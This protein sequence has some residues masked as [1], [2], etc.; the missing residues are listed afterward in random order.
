MTC[1]GK[2][3]LQKRKKQR[4][5]QSKDLGS[6]SIW[7][8]IGESLDILSQA[9]ENHPTHNDDQRRENRNPKQQIDY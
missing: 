1:D 4:V 2:L 6:E 9:Q 8:S 5:I 3:G 7:V